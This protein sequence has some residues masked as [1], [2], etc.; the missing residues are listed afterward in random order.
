MAAIFVAA[1]DFNLMING[2]SSWSC[3]DIDITELSDNLLEE[4]I[5]G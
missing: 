2:S 3:L 4:D 1:A 5:L